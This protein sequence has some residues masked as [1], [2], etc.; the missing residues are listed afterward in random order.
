LDIDFNSK[1]YVIKNPSLFGL[2]FACLSTD[3]EFYGLKFRFLQK[4]GN[5]QHT[6]LQTYI[7]GSCFVLKPKD[8]KE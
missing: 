4:Q 7:S 3:R 8:P 6:S 1:T 2:G 5:G